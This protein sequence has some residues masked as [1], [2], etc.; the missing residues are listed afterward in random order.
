VLKRQLFN[1]ITRL[2]LLSIYAAFFMVQTLYTPGNN[3][4]VGNYFVKGSGPGQKDQHTV[5]KL[6]SKNDSS[7]Q[8]NIRLNKR[9]QP[10]AIL[11][12]ESAVLPAFPIHRSLYQV[13]KPT[14][15]LL[16]SSILTDSLR[17]PPSVG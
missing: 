6:T 8:V 17:G 14:T 3:D 13:I 9:F 15:Y 4:P 5:K 10:E 16:I 7:K 1:Y 11:T 12:C 2:L